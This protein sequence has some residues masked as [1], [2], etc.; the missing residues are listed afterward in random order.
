MYNGAAKSAASAV[1]LVAEGV[2]AA[3][4]AS[5]ANRGT[6]SI[7]H[8]STLSQ[9]G[10]EG[11]DLALDR[12]VAIVEALFQ[13]RDYHAFVGAGL[14]LTHDRGPSRIERENLLRTR[15]E[16]DAAELLLAKFHVFGELHDRD[17]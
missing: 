13:S 11:G 8:E 16:K 1:A 9:I 3:A 4:L 5:V 15:L 17:A 14:D 6:R 10:D 2:T 12:S 7:L